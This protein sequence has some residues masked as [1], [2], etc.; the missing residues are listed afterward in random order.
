MYD[1]SLN[2]T[3]KTKEDRPKRGLRAKGEG[4]LRIS[5]GVWLKQLDMIF[6]A[7]KTALH[8]NAPRM[9]STGKTSW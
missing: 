2:G 4:Y 7:Y 3:V 1:V 6:I 5:Q 9:H 8:R